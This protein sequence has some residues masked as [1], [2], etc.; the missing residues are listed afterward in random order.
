MLTTAKN[1]LPGAAL[2]AKEGDEPDGNEEDGE[3]RDSPPDDVTPLRV[4]VTV[5]HVLGFVLDAPEHDHA[6]QTTKRSLYVW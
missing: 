2:L 6:L 1:S 5:T 4:H 3:Q